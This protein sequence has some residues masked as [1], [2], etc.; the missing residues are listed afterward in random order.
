MAGLNIR[1]IADGELDAKGQ[2]VGGFNVEFL[3]AQGTEAFV[4]VAGFATA[5]DAHEWTR[6]YLVKMM[7]AALKTN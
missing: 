4:S 1:V 2:H 5:A 7:A 6:E 3:N